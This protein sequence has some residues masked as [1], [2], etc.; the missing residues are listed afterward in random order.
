MQKR[1][2]K[3]LVLVVFISM[4]F[5]LPDHT[6]ALNADI[7]PISSVTLTDD[8]W[9]DSLRI[10][11][12][13]ATYMDYDE[14]GDED[15]ILTVFRIITP[16]D[17]WEGGRIE[18]G[19]AVVKPSGE[20]LII[21]FDFRTRDGAEITIVWFNFADEPGWYTLYIKAAAHNGDDDISPAYVKHIFDP[22]GGGDKGIPE[23]EIVTIED[24]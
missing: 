13:E 11:V 22:P 4:L 1:H 19:C 15:D 6:H 10:V 16:D 7:T 24:L 12:D 2:F 14:D 20:A 8:D 5:V 23:I 9:E 3:L 18:V 17:D 21:H